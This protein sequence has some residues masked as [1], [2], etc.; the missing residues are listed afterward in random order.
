LRIR[1][2]GALLTSDNDKDV[3]RKSAAATHVTRESTVA[4]PLAPNAA[5][6]PP[7]P[8]TSAIFPALPD[9]NNTTP[10]RNRATTTCTIIK[11]VSNTGIYLF[12]RTMNYSH[13]KDTWQ[14]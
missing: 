6:D 9:C 7:P 10:I 1:D 13:F 11:I 4:A 8:K 5:I 14:A 2:D 12:G 3:T